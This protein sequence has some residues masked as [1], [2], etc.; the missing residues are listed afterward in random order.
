[1]QIRENVNKR[2]RCETLVL[3]CL[4]CK[5]DIY[6]F[7]TSPQVEKEKK[8]GMMDINLR[9]VAAVTSL[10]GDITFLNHLLNIHTKVI[11]GIL[12][13]NEH[14]RLNNRLYA[15]SNGYA[16]H[17]N[18]GDQVSSIA[19]IWAIY[20]H[21]IMGPPEESVASQHSDCPN[22]D[23]TWCKYHKDKIFNQNIYDRLK[24]LTFG[25]C[26]E[27]HVNVGSLKIRTSPLTTWFGQDARK[28]FV[29][30]A[31]L[32]FL[33]VNEMKWNEGAHGRKSF[34]ET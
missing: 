5:K 32:L 3:F 19:A 18:K 13:K 23:K 9:Y 2:I 34:M 30:K 17:N 11:S 7:N 4:S 29:A 22:G 26:G 14:R 6:S 12:R 24:C 1:M 10:R 20:H 33:F 28:E 15:N 8:K 31:D 25:F 16:I 21:M 27:L